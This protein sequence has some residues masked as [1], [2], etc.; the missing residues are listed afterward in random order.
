MA[1]TTRLVFAT[2]ISFAA[3]SGPGTGDPQATP[4]DRLVANPAY[5]AWSAHP[6]GSWARFSIQDD[7]GTATQTLVLAEKVDFA[8]IVGIY[9][10][11]PP[12]STTRLGWLESAVWRDTAASLLDQAW[13][14][15]RP[16]GAGPLAEAAET[17]TL[18]GK[19]LACTRRSVTCKLS[20]NEVQEWR[21]WW[22]PAV[23][24]GLAQLERRTLLGG[25]EVHSW[26]RVLEAIGTDPADA[27]VPWPP[28]KAQGDGWGENPD[29]KRWDGFKAGA[30]V[31]TVRQERGDFPTAPSRWTETLLDRTSAT[32]LLLTERESNDAARPGLGAGWISPN[33][34]QLL[35]SKRAL[36]SVRDETGTVTKRSLA[37]LE[38]AGRQLECTLTDQSTD[39]GENEV[40]QIK[41]W[42]HSSVPG[43]VV[44]REST[45]T[46]DGTL[47][48]SLTV[49]VEAFGP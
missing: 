9:V 25:K 42:T 32:L 7:E 15:A 8:V 17:L 28:P 14:I 5:A 44:R 41:T 37:T 16:V 38:I 19:A 6:V 45:T 26:R 40:V 4:V 34:P 2:L 10:P 12:G 20:E 18:G 49:I 24:G 33:N 48:S 43:H 1:R 27:K 11:P 47:R 35:C 39:L 30:W 3:V 21:S 46:F 31:R 23:P 29:F 36:S 13:F 22:S